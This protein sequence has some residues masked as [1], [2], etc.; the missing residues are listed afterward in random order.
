[1]SSGE[2]RLERLRFRELH[3]PFKVAFRHASAE[4]A[5]TSSV[6]VEAIAADGTI[7]C[8]ESCPR[9]YVTGETLA[10]ARAFVLGHEATIRSK[11]TGVETL[12]QWLE[13]HH[14]DIDAS[15]AAWCAVELALLDLFGKRQRTPV[16]DLLS[17]PPL[18]GRFRYTAVLGDAPEG[19]F[20]AMAEQYWR[21][22]FRDV[23]VKLSGDAGRDRTKMDVFREW[24]PE[25]VRVR[26]DTNNLWPGPD[27][28]ISA[29]RGLQYPLFAVEEPIGSNRHAQLPRI[30]RALGCR[31]VL[32]ESLVRREQ[33]ALLDEPASQWIVNV[34]VSKM[35]GLIRSVRVVNEAR[36]LGIGVIVGAQ[37]GETSLLTR[38]GL[39]VAHAAGDG[40]VAQEGAFGTFLLERDVCDPPL[41]FGA[42]GVLD[43]SDHPNLTSAGLG[44]FSIEGEG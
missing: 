26:A 17:L 30:A 10:T 5:E 3:I 4:R 36:A 34:R 27:E 8:G 9:P 40:L 14:D 29:L 35:G 24:P 1:M 11:I 21:L 31:I 6:W 19:P 25:S 22:G 2:C 28:A 32:D 12:Q 13:E 39:T 37:V 38:A 42:G 18:A 20:R 33:L 41:M 16:E 43:V 7:G 15:P 44:T 23:K